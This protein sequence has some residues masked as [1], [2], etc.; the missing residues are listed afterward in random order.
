MIDES[1]TD[2]FKRATTGV[3]FE[4]RRI[5]AIILINYKLA[6]GSIRLLGPCRGMFSN[7]C[8]MLELVRLSKYA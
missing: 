1:A 2:D 6:V 7:L 8:S 3:R 5:R 4:Y